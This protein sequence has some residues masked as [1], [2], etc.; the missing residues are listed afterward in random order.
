MT[1]QGCGPWVSIVASVGLALCLLAAPSA[2]AQAAPQEPS[3][4]TCFEQAG[5]RHGVAPVLLQAIAL[6]ESGMRA[7]ALN[8]NRDGSTD[9]GLMQINSRW[10]PALARQGITTEQLWNPCVSVHVGAWILAD[11]FRRL[12]Q[13]WDAVGAYNAR[14]PALRMRYAQAIHTRVQQISSSHRLF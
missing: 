1:L 10:L 13:N 8:R 7:N 6:Q 2:R 5:A 9:I 12:G 11:N 4:H 14:N 3:H